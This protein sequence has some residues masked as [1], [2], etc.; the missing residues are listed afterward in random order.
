MCSVNLF[1][2]L[3][4]CFLFGVIIFFIDN[5]YLFWLIVFYLLLLSIVDRNV[6]SLVLLFFVSC[7]LLFC[8]FTSK[9]RFLVQVCLF[10]NFVLLFVSA[11]SK[12]DRENYRYKYLYNDKTKRK[13]LFYDSYREKVY[14]KLKEKYSSVSDKMVEKELDKLYLYARVRFYGYGNSVTS[15]SVSSFS[16]YDLIFLIT[17]VFVIFIIYIYR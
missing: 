17:S 7:V 9:I 10:L 2:K 13:S 1:L 16:F 3:L 8:L 6:K 4:F 11:T 15:K 14:N 5:Y 12:I